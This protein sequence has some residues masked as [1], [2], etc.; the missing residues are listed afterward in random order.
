MEAGLPEGVFTIVTGQGSVA[1]EAILTHPLVR[2]LAFTG[3]TEVGKR[4]MELG[5]RDIKRVS[6]ELGGKSANLIFDDCDFDRAVASAVSSSLGNAGQDC[7]ARSRIFVERSIHDRFVERFVERT[8][9][10]R[11]G[12]TSSPETE[13]GPLI[14]L[15]HRETVRS[16]LAVGDQEGA[17]RLCGGE[18]PHGDGFADGLGLVVPHPG[19]LRARR[20]GD[21]CDAGGD[22]RSGGLHRAF[23]LRGGS[24]QARERQPRDGLSGSLW[25]R[26]I[27]RALR[28]A[29][30]LETGVVLAGD[31]QVALEAG[32]RMSGPAPAVRQQHHHTGEQ[33]PLVFRGGDELVEDDLRAVREVAEPWKSSADIVRPLRT[34]WWTSHDSIGICALIMFGTEV[35]KQTAADLV[36][37]KKLAAFAL[38]EAEAGSTPP[39]SKRSRCRCPTA[40]PG[41]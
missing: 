13:M 11:V 28:V 22:L 29:R 27:G 35:D 31:L 2:K 4:V 25:T 32:A 15:L 5:S 34:C 23:R 40:R 30:A 6:L 39:M 36:T 9:A 19:G 38:T 18:V 17:E 20:S 16:F 7:C 3:S 33:A 21:A 1:G 24:G 37:G 8:R 41:S 26:D 12:P 14:S 10:I